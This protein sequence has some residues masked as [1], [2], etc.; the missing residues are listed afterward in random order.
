MTAAVFDSDEKNRFVTYLAR[1]GIEHRV[2]RVRPV[3]G[4]EDWVFRMP[5]KQFRVPIGEL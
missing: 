3:C 5:L 4:R 1:S 2:S